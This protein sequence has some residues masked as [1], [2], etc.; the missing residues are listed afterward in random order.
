MVSR[1]RD[2]TIASINSPAA[3]VSAGGVSEGPIGLVAAFAWEVR[4]LLRRRGDVQKEG[5]IRSFSLGGV[6]AKLVISGAGLESSYRA[7]RR[8]LECCRLRG[9]V[10]IGFAG[11]LTDSLSRGDVVIAER[12]IDAR[13]GETFR[14]ID[15]LTLVATARR[16]DLLCAARVITST[17]EKHS[18]AAEWNALAVDMESAGVARAAAES[19]VAFSAIKA[20]TDAAGRSISI[21]FARCQSDDKSFSLRKIVIEGLRTPNGIRDL[22]SL[23]RGARV[24]ARALAAALC[25]PG[26]R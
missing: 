23:A 8:L 13:T 21:D 17:M 1:A 20:V 5:A 3:R 15:A 25:A 10:S 2:D 16:G 24:A 11:G 18:L 22:W 9:I 14:C 26:V 7:A 4:P 12:V 19:G 6:P